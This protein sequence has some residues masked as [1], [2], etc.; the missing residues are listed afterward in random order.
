MDQAYEQDE[1]HNVVTIN[2]SR[3]QEVVSLVDEV[4]ASGQYDLFDDYA[5]NFLWEF[6]NGE[7]SV[8]PCSAPWP[9]ARRR[10]A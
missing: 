10:A 2:Q 4:I 6:E 8:F 3:L 7:E 1:Q 5:Q 9:T